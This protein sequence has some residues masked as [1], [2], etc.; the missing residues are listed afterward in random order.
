[1]TTYYTHI[2]QPSD[3]PPPDYDL[4]YGG[5]GDSGNGFV[6]CIPVDKSKSLQIVEVNGNT[7]EIT[8]GQRKVGGPP[9]DYIGLAPSQECEI[10]VGK[11]PRD[12]MEDELLP[13]FERFGE[14]WDLRLMINPVS[15][16]SR[17]YAFIKF[18]ETKAAKKAVREMENYEIRP[19]KQLSVT[20]CKP[21]VRLFVGN[22]PKVK[23][24][25]ELMAEFSRRTEGL[26]DVIVYNSPDEK[27]K[28]RGFCF[29][30]Y[31]SHKHAYLA[32]KKLSTT[33]V[34]FW[35]CDIIVDWADPMEEPDDET[36]AKVKVLYVRNLTHAVTQEKLRQLFSQFGSIERVKKIKDY[37]F[38][39]F[40]TREGA[41][42]ALNAL[43]GKLVCGTNL[44]IT[45]AKPP[46]DKKKRE[47]ILRARE[48]RTMQL[49]TQS[50]R[51][52]DIRRGSPPTQVGS[53]AMMAERNFYGQNYLSSSVGRGDF[54]DHWAPPPGPMSLPYGGGQD[55]RMYFMENELYQYCPYLQQQSSRPHFEAQSQNRHEPEFNLFPEAKS[56]HRPSMTWTRGRRS[57]KSHRL[58]ENPTVVGAP[59]GT[60]WS[61]E[62]DD[63][64]R[65]NCGLKPKPKARPEPV[66]SETTVSGSGLAVTATPAVGAEQPEE[67]QPSQGSSSS[68][69][70]WVEW[71]ARP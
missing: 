53:E 24:K 71:R 37:A 13:I 28:N 48:R 35:G 45:W 10:F 47:T 63:N 29:L 14:I 30:E 56:Q 43:N 54:N 59:E 60:H 25:E 52:V 66:T 38:I 46:T 12:I 4:N 15:L 55:P 36:M 34:K 68:S 39:H 2:Y 40:A 58:F 64:W 33:S 17:G 49:L 21:K 20:L 67:Q 3:G 1:M 65:A 7:V 32:K 27:K 44:E 26:V 11:I 9:A 57:S 61:A 18:K 42:R 41:T 22:I 62:D 5:E 8:P 6:G 31:M 50:P 51:N 23:A 69:I 16:K 70:P 19:G